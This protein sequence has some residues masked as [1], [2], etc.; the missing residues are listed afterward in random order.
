MAGDR[1]PNL[2]RISCVGAMSAPKGVRQL[3]W[4]IILG[5]DNER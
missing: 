1:L 2:E 5:S 3:V 4:V